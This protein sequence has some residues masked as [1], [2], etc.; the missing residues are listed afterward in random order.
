MERRKFDSSTNVW[1]DSGLRTYLNGDWLDG[2]ATLQEKAVQT[3]ITT[4]IFRTDTFNTTQDKVFLLSEADLFG[5]H[6]YGQTPTDSKDYT[7][8]GQVLVPNIEM[9][10][11]STTCWLRSP[12]SSTFVNVVYDDGTLS[13]NNSYSTNGVRPALWITMP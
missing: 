11:S 9:R 6:S 5:T 7:Y 2:K 8:N 4:R 13:I 12:Y 3:D 10:K 1:K